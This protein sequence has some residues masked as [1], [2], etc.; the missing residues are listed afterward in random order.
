MMPGGSPVDVDRNQNGKQYA[1]CD[2]EE[3]PSATVPLDSLSEARPRQQALKHNEPPPAQTAV[4]DPE[5]SVRQA[6]GG[7]GSR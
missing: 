2:C 4:I 1:R 5:E 6:Q 7:S 3:R